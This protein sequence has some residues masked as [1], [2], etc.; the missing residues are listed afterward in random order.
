MAQI[1]IDGRVG[2]EGLKLAADAMAPSKLNGHE[3]FLHFVAASFLVILLQTCQQDAYSPRCGLSQVCHSDAKREASR[4]RITWDIPDAGSA[5]KWFAHLELHL[6]ARSNEAK[7]K[8]ILKNSQ[9][10]N[11]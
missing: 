5:D 10:G 6:Q 2:I 9:H 4:R 1:E 3:P 8:R 11:Q 7:A